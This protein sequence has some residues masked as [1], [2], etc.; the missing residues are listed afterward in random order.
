MVLMGSAKSSSLL[1]DAPNKNFE[2]LFD[3]TDHENRTLLS[4]AVHKNQL[5]V[6]KL[7]LKEDPAYEPMSER[8]RSDLK[9]LIHKAC[10]EGYKGIVKVLCEKY[11]AGKTKYA[12]HSLLIDAIKRGNKGMQYIFKI[13]LKILVTSITRSS[14]LRTY[15]F[16][17]ET[18][19]V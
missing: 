5:D 7:I 4:L 14:I 12:G 16:H 18:D 10:K 15:L 9:S 3:R 13:F 8:K 11:E 2:A 6:V 17:S 19:F 1:K